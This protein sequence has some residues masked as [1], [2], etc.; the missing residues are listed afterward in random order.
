MRVF[1][2]SDDLI[3]PIQPSILPRRKKPALAY[4]AAPSMQASEPISAIVCQRGTTWHIV[5]KVG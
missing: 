5:A 2:V 1:I 4:F 3:S